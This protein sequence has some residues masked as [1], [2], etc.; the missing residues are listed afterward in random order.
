MPSLGGP[1][2]RIVVHWVYIRAPSFIKTSTFVLHEGKGTS[3][4][5]RKLSV[6][7]FCEDSM[8]RGGR[9]KD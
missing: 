7:C 4:V 3:A 9:K 8:F 2:A 6:H 1:R 5:G